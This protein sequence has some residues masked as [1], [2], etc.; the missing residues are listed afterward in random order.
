MFNT[1][2]SSEAEDASKIPTEEYILSIIQVVNL[3]KTVVPYV[4]DDYQ[5]S[6]DYLNFATSI[7]H[8]YFPQFDMSTEIS[9]SYLK[10]VYLDDSES[11][12]L[13]IPEFITQ[14]FVYSMLPNTIKSNANNDIN[15]DLMSL[16]VNILENYE[17]D[18]DISIYYKH[19]MEILKYFNHIVHNRNFLLKLQ[20]NSTIA[21]KALSGLNPCP[22]SNLTDYYIKTVENDYSSECLEQLCSILNCEEDKTLYDIYYVNPNSYYYVPNCLCIPLFCFDDKTTDVPDIIKPIYDIVTKHNKSSIVSKFYNDVVSNL[23]DPISSD[24]SIIDKSNIT[25]ITIAYPFLNEEYFDTSRFEYTYKMIS[26]NSDCRMRFNRKTPDDTSYP[27][28]IQT[29]IFDQKF[30]P[31]LKII[32]LYF[33]EEETLENLIKNYKDKLMEIKNYLLIAYG[34]LVVI[35]CCVIIKWLHMKVDSFRIRISEMKNIHKLIINSDNS[36]GKISLLQNKAKMIARNMNKDLAYSNANTPQ[37]SQYKKQLTNQI[38]NNYNTANPLSKNSSRI[39]KNN[40][41]GSD[42]SLDDEYADNSLIEYKNNKFSIIDNGNRSLTE[43]NNIIRN[44]SNNIDG[45]IVN[46]DDNNDNEEEMLDSLVTNNNNY[47][48]IGEIENMRFKDELQEIYSIIIDNIKDF[49]L[50]FEIDKNVYVEDGFVKRYIKYINKRQYTDFLLPEIDISNTSLDCINDEANDSIS[51]SESNILNS[52]NNTNNVN[53]NN[54]NTINQSYSV[55]NNNALVEK[56]NAEIVKVE[57]HINVL[58]RKSKLITNEYFSSKPKHGA[59]FFN[60]NTNNVSNQNITQNKSSMSLS[61]SNSMEDQTMSE[62]E[63]RDIKTNLSV[64]ILYEVISCEFLHLNHYYKNFYYREF[65]Q[66]K[67]ID[68]E[69][70]INK[71]L[72]NDQS[73]NNEMSDSGKVLK[74]MNFYYTEIILRWKNLFEK[75]N[76]I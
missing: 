69:D 45:E 38:T 22:Y 27:Y 5:S 17:D 62:F 74:A 3:D 63:K 49:T 53:N 58:S 15:I 73:S 52:N 68:L 26:L 71:Y 76:G 16:N 35:I 7:T 66:E 1:Q 42:N 72:Y 25:Q 33:Y 54:N 64:A 4:S 29:E 34:V 8:N 19:D 46:N 10:D 57:D 36:K 56:N 43:N 61:N 12:I 11:I 67:L 41:Y 50:E 40:Y 47:A 37:N 32:R 51:S 2:R 9:K 21:L 14:N 30:D 65:F 75:Q 39:N 44:L 23:S 31:E 13:R 28:R 24:A 20:A 70:Y 60:N 59:F 55:N 6:F 18:Y 48:F